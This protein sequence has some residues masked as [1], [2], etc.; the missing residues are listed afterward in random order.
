MPQQI[1]RGAVNNK[2]GITLD[3]RTK[4]F[5]AFILGVVLLTG[6]YNG[7]MAWA[8]PTL[9]AIP[10]VLLLS[11]R[12][13][14]AAVGYS[15][16]FLASYFAMTYLMP[17]TSGPLNFLVMIVFGI[18]LQFLPCIMMF[19]FVFSTTTVSEFM[20]AMERMH[21]TDKITIPMSV[22]FRFFPTVNEEFGDIND[23][24][25]MRGI[26]FG[27][28]NLG[29]MIEYR[30]VPMMVCS[31]RIGEDLAAAALTRGL[32]APVKRTNV[33]SVGFHIQDLIILAVCAACLVAFG[34]WYVSVHF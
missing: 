7:G 13:W 8:R 17:I 25:R 27:K 15:L 18:F 32:G 3:P 16:A 29:A 26:S 23:A 5:V 2:G 21:L 1:L 9:T 28:G 20:A 10:L 11:V 33:C 24:M 34:E 19:Y 14:G 6:G 31:V 12:K 22:M 30:L 4:I